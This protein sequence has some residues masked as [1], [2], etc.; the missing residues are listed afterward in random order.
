MAFK[1]NYRDLNEAELQANL[2]SKLIK[3]IDNI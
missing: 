3:E 1:S 2:L